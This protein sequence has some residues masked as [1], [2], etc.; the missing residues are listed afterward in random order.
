MLL[1]NTIWNSPKKEGDI[2]N[3]NLMLFKHFYGEDTESKPNEELDL[4]VQDNTL[5]VTE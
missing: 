1:Q 2:F 3:T 4:P 5:D